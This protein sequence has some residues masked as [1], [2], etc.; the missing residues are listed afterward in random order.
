M[1]LINWGRAARFLAAAAISV[2]ALLPAAPVQA[3]SERALYLYYTHTKETARIVFKRNGQYV[4]SGL[5]ELN[6]F[7]RD[8]RR[9]EP[10]K[11][12]PRLF[13]LVWEVYQDVG[14]SQPINIVSAYRSPATN[15]MLASK[16]SG[17]AD[18]SQHMRGTA[19]DFFIPGVS[20]TK[21][22][23]AAMKKQ[24]GGVG[25]YPTSGSPFV[26]LDTG[27]VR[28]WPRMT[29]AQLKEIFPDGRTMHVPTDGTPLSQ[30]GYRVAMAEW[31][32]C[33]AYPCNGSSSGTQ[34]ASNDSGGSGRTL[35]DVLFGGNEQAA[36]AAQIQT[37]SLAPQTFRQVAP[38][39]PVS[40]PA[41]L[42]GDEFQVASVSD[43]VMPF[44][45][46]GSAPLSEGEMGAVAVTMPVSLPADLRPE[47][48]VTALAALTA[49]TMPTPRVIMTD[50]PS[51]LLTAY[52][53]APTPEP[54]AQR[55]LEMIIEGS[56]TASTATPPSP[57][58]R[59]PILPPLTAATGLRTA[60]LGGPI[61]NPL[62]GLFNGTFGATNA[63]S[64]TP[65]AE[66]LAEHVAR[67]PAP[68]DMRR[69]DLVAPDLEH[70][71]DIFM[72]PASLTSNRY[73]VIFDHD[74]ADFD[75]TP[76]MGRHV[77]VKGIGDVDA[78]PVHD[79]FIRVTPLV[80]ASN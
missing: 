35:M 37:A 56:T 28:A 71:A 12:D 3:A 68:G 10:T 76:E 2:S 39:L 50:A 38:V 61:A 78:V 23:A 19:M 73:A 5:N 1:G 17:V 55:A 79:R 72:D 15:A 20:L 70:V 63:A 22:R 29:R 44:S 62:T 53:A 26:H 7:L 52:A 69:R 33:H 46:T 45:S 9:N 58:T 59:L 42:G 24:V 57:T 4:Q 6:R 27:S 49:P 48:A 21:L 60:S 64:P 18:N 25:Y 30:E 77:L 34:V 75:P 40:R 41:D 43:T 13:D 36:P 11:M 54:G 74:E 16:S 47:N 80:V 51:D 65:L 8:W 31:K 67:R 66:A 14:G 32:R